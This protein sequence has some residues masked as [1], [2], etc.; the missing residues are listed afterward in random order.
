M[1]RQDGVLLGAVEA[2]RSIEYYSLPTRIN[3]DE[4]AISFWTWLDMLS[5]N[6]NELIDYRHEILT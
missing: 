1:E 2:Q 3:E 6:S 4:L 5:N